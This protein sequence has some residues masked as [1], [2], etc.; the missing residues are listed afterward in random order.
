VLLYR[1]YPLAVVEL[2]L[3]EAPLE[4]GADV[5]SYAMAA[6]IPFVLA[7]DG[8]HIL[9]MARE[10]AE[11]LGYPEFPAPTELWTALGR[12]PMQEDPRIYPPAELPRTRVTVQIALA[13][14]RAL[15]AILAG[16]RRVLLAM[17]EETGQGPVTLQIAWKLLGSGRCKKA[18][19]LVS[20]REM[21]DY[22]EWLFRPFGDRAATAGDGRPVSGKEQ[23]LLSPID[24]FYQGSD[25]S[26][27]AARALGQYDLILI[28]D[29]EVE[30]DR[31]S[32]LGYLGGSLVVGFSDKE[33][34]S[35]EVTGL[36]GP[37]RFTYPLEAE[38]AMRAA[39]AEPVEDMFDK[40]TKE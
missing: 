32:L 28:A 11:A 23:V 7:A 3:L 24:A 27:S 38:L 19:Y 1:L 8:E 6:E 15:D 20:G 35:E 18:L 25:V 13:V 31:E 14:A 36:F 33:P 10:G 30:L 2:G 26:A 4:I 12:V 39:A 22:A 16:E 37:P 34:P 40:L 9:G 29:T 5:A 17:A 21:L